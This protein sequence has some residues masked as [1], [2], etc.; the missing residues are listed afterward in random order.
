MTSC[1]G[2][3]SEEAGRAGVADLGRKVEVGCVGDVLGESEARHGELGAI[4][5]VRVGEEVLED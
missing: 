3:V 5:Q 1:E 4:N 2:F